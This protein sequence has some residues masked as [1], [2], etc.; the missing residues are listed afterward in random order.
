MIMSNFIDES[1]RHTEL[2]QTYTLRQ[3]TILNIVNRS[4][5]AGNNDSETLSALHTKQVS[6]S[7]IQ[8]LKRTGHYLPAYE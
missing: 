8:W 2:Y 1:E 5:I 7:E 4:K 3:E 6:V